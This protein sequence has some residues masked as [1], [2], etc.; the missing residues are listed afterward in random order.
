MKQIDSIPAKRFKHQTYLLQL[1]ERGRIVLPRTLR[2]QLGLRP[3]EKLNAIV[4]QDALEII[5]IK[6]QVA[7]AQGILSALNPKRYLSEEL[8]SERRKEAE[9]E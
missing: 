7:K 8:I 3:R 2:N 4:K 5:P 1:D 9:L 6:A